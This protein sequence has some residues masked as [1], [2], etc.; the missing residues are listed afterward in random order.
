MRNVDGQIVG[1]RT[2]NPMDGSKRCVT[3][4]QLGIMHAIDDESIVCDWL[5]VTEGES[6][7][8]AALDFGF[9]AIA[10]PGCQTCTDVVVEFVARHR[11]PRV[12]IVADADSP[13]QSGAHAL[14]RRIASTAHTPARVLTL[15]SAKDLRAWKSLPDSSH[16]DLLALLDAPPALKH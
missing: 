1:I 7:A 9:N 4:S 6:D 11:P 5:I 12:A 14:A 16:H 3:A 2:R 8:A 15:P 10:R 13:G